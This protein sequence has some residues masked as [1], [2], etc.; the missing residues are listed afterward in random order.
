MQDYFL[1]HSLSFKKC[2]SLKNNII[3]LAACL[4]GL[5]G[6]AQSNPQILGLGISHFC[7]VEADERFLEKNPHLRAGAEAAEKQLESELTAYDQSA[8]RKKADIKIIPIVFHVLHD[9]GSENISD[10]QVEDAV[11]ILNRDYARKNADTSEVAAAFQGIIGK[12]D[13]EFRLAKLDPNGNVSSGI[14]RIKTQETY[15]GDDGSKVNYWP[16]ENYMNIWVVKVIQSGAAGY[17]RRPNAVNSSFAASIDG[18]VVLN[19]YCGSIGTAS[20]TRSRTLTH[21]V[22]HWLNLSH[23]WGNSN[24]PE[25]PANCN[26]DDG[27]QDTPLTEGQ[28]GGCSLNN[29]TCGTLDNVQNYMNYASCDRMFTVQQINRVRTALG[30]NV[31]KRNNLVTSANLALT[32]IDRL[33]SVDFKTENNIV[34]FG[35]QVQ[36]DD[37]SFYTQN[38]WEWLFYGA[39][40]LTSS[41]QNPV[42][43]YNKPGLY[44]VSLKVSNGMDALSTNKPNFIWALPEVGLSIPINENFE[45]A[46]LP[47]ENMISYNEFNDAVAFEI[48]SS[49]GFQGGKALYLNNHA[50]VDGKIDAAIVGPVDVS[51]M[52]VLDLRFKYAHALVNSSNQEFLKVFISTD[53]GVTWSLKWQKVG[54]LLPTA[55]IILNSFT[56]SYTD[57]Q[58]VTISNFTSA[59]RKSET[60]LVKFEFTAGGGNNLYL[61]DI[62]FDGIF[63]ASPRLEYPRDG[64][65]DLGEDALLN[66]KAVRAVEE[67]QYELDT[68]VNFGSMDFKTGKTTYISVKPD[69]A[70]TES[71]VAGLNHGDSYYWRVRAKAAGVWSDWSDVWTFTVSSNGVST[72]ELL[73]E[74]N[75]TLIYPNPVNSSLNVKSKLLTM[76]YHLI[77]I[78]G[79]EIKKARVNSEQFSIETSSLQSGI[80]FLKLVDFN[81][82][83]SVQRVVISH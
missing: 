53:C 7:D 12:G 56:P 38:T 61:D 68:D 77:D 71:L 15:V 17:T 26:M 9:N 32:G 41:S 3:L 82:N 72:E 8:S 83:I 75:E 14:N 46:T 28:S 33:L 40:V 45:N 42:V 22:G 54:A 24:N 30:S 37:N 25:D 4:L 60:L 19:T 5:S 31:A 2:I 65:A 52:S 27:V 73:D 36:F 49:G 74:S 16:R 34:C 50:N 79:K 57:W 62:N 64:A 51:T 70:D 55:G 11:R 66:W 47:S 69:K 18:I 76:H 21:E 29:S 1:L 39:K 81:N 48:V 43:T 63:A 80:Y 10:A 59:E 67:Y 20:A 23:T 78:Y 44:D 13:I 6:F 58:A 35:G